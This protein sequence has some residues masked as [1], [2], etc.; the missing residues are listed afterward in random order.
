MRKSIHS[1]CSSSKSGSFVHTI[2][3]SQYVNETNHLTTILSGRLMIQEIGSLSHL[4][5]HRL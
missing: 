4:T 2:V 5:K 3:D 1:L